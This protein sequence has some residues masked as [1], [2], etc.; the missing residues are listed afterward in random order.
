MSVAIYQLKYPIGPFTK[1][2]PLDGRVVASAIDTIASFPT[3]LRLAVAT[4]TSE[5][6]DTPYRPE[7]WTVRQ[8][9]HHCADSHMNSFIRFKLALTEDAPII[10]PYYEDRWAELADTKALDITYS[11]IL[12]DGLHARWAALLRSLEPTALKRVFI[13]PEQGKQL[14]LDEA[15]ALYAWH[16]EHHLAHITTLKDSKNWT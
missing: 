8:V 13:H 2:E 4:L 16:C 11:L 10:K 3:K 12:L 7:G 1:P 15:T 14:A 9:V 5:Q 6:L